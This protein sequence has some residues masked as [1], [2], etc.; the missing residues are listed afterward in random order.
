MINLDHEKINFD[1][2]IFFQKEKLSLINRWILSRFYSSLDETEKYLGNYQFNEAAN[3]LYSFFWHEFCDWY[4]EIIKSDIQNAHNQLTMY[5][6]LDKFLRAI[7]PFMPFVSEEIWQRLSNMALAK[8]GKTASLK[9][10]PSIMVSSFPHIQK[11]IIDKKAE[12]AMGEVFEII[13]TIRNMRAELDIPVQAPNLSVKITS[14]KDATRL[15]VETNAT[16]IKN[17]A[18]I[19][20]LA[21]EEEYRHV[22]GEFVNILKDMHIVIPLEGVIDIGKHTKKIDDKISKAQNDIKSKETMLANKDFI[23]RAPAEIIEGEKEK[24]K[25]L[26]EEV[27]KLK[28]VKDGLNS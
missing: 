9:P 10:A 12:K 19:A 8:E 2:C 24:L 7:H 5:K 28:G 11:Q 15:L 13:T 26:N 3:T 16:H 21:V 4:L 20:N 6:I 27:R 14:T 25:A 22:T 17:L 18:R 1:L 23:K